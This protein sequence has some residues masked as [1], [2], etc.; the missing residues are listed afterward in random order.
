MQESNYGKFILEAIR[1]WLALVAVYKRES[2]RLRLVVYLLV[3]NSV[4]IQ[5]R[6]VKA[7]VFI[8]RFL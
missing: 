6:D 5:V 7:R 2:T 3:D 1:R 8:A 4:F